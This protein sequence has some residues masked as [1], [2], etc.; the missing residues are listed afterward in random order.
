MGTAALAG[1]RLNFLNFVAIPIT[2][3]VG[4]DYAINMMRRRVDE[5]GQPPEQLVAT[6]GGAL[7]LC[8]LTTVIGY[9][10]LLVAANR[11]IASFG[12][13]A[14]LGEIACL[15]TALVLLPA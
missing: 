8:S 6:M 4:A 7:V 12:L 9:G 15:M 11:A 2:I 5:P 3:G 10:T 13:L 1:M 14:A